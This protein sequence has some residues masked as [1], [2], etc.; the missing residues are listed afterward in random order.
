MC[1]S[2]GS[3]LWVSAV[4]LRLQLD[5]INCL[6]EHFFA[7]HSGTI[8]LF[9]LFKCELL[10]VNLVFITEELARLSSVQFFTF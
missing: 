3:E 9:F 1:E 5:E 8:G 10:S 7:Y 6:I 2:Q 4:F